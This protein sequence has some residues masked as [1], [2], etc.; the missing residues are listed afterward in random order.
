MA[1]KIK[2]VKVS[3]KQFMQY[4]KDNNPELMFMEHVHYGFSTGVMMY[5]PATDSYSGFELKT[6]TITKYLVKYLTD[7]VERTDYVNDELEDKS[8]K[9]LRNIIFMKTMWVA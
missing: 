1:K 7:L 8:R 6:K 3:S 4:V 5:S 9:A 2:A